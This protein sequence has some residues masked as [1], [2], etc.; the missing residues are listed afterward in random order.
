MFFTVVALTPGHDVVLCSG[1]CLFVCLR[2]CLRPVF[3]GRHVQSR[4]MVY[5]GKLQ[6]LSRLL[7]DNALPIIAEYVGYELNP[8]IGLLAAKILYRV[9]QDEVTRLP[10][11]QIVE[12]LQ[13]GPAKDA[14]IQGL[15]LR[16]ARDVDVESG[17]ACDLD[18]TDTDDGDVGMGVATAG[19]PGAP[20]TSSAATATSSDAAAGRRKDSVVREHARETILELLLRNL[21]TPGLNLTHYLLGL[22]GAIQQAPAALSLD[23]PSM[24]C[25]RAVLHLVDVPDLVLRHPRTAEAC[26]ELLYNLCRNKDVSGT[27][28][29]LLQRHLR[30][31]QRFFLSHLHRLQSLRLPMTGPGVGAGTAT[32]TGTGLGLGSAGMAGTGLTGLEFGPQSVAAMRRC[33]GW[34]LRGVAL[35]LL[36]MANDETPDVAHIRAVLVDLFGRVAD[37]EGAGQQSHIPLLELLFAQ[38]LSD[39]KPDRPPAALLPALDAVGSAPGPVVDAGTR[40]LPLYVCVE[41]GVWSVEWVGVECGVWSVGCAE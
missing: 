31:N 29:H 41:C 30:N 21:E 27:V 17:V 13:R 38:Q 15:A 1:L 25:F 28:M 4:A 11:V 36:A 16:L 2:V 20:T 39:P 18:G 35:D 26:Y 33:G 7:G 3:P 12:A 19:V 6:Q 32:G 10:S 22:H 24:A 5:E 8:D 40:Q 34:M 14:I 37:S 23:A 9:S